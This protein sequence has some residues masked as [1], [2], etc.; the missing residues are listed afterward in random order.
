MRVNYVIASYA[1]TKCVSHRRFCEDTTDI[2]PKDYLKR[3]LQQLGT[4]P[5]SLSQIT[6]MKAQV[7]LGT[8]VYSEYYDVDAEIAALTALGTQVK[9]YIVGNCG[10]SYGQYI[11]AFELT[12][13]VGQEF[14]YWILVEDDYVPVLPHF[15]VVLMETHKTVIGRAGVL[16]AWA[17]SNNYKRLHLAHSLCIIDGNAIEQ[18]FGKKSRHRHRT[19]VKQFAGVQPAASQRLFSKLFSDAKLPL[20]DYSD[21][22]YTPYW[23]GNR[24]VDCSE[25]IPKNDAAIFMPLQC[26]NEMPR[27]I[28]KHEFILRKQAQIQVQTQTQTQ[29]QDKPKN[30]QKAQKTRKDQKQPKKPQSKRS[31]NL[32]NVEMV[33]LA[34]HSQK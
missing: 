13:N 3:H 19:A 22:Y 10:V 16:C 18:T 12:E 24:I 5:H 25:N 30:E 28:P 32:T 17:S 4:V 29:T 26:P 33:R 21:Y 2:H 7:P 8:P 9:T 27:F 34:M 20:K 6:L 14:D 15:D 11:H 1:G 31:K 23:T